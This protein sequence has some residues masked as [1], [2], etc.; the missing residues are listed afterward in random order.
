MNRSK[1]LGVGVALIAAIYLVPALVVF[2]FTSIAGSNDEDN[3]DGQPVAIGPKPRWWVPR[4]AHDYD[5][6][7]GFGYAPDGWPFVVWKP[8][9]LLFLKA[10][11]YV[12][13]KE[14]R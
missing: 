8:V 3:F 4:A 10:K 6:P 9:C 1:Q 11:G 14:W 7:G 2:D 5:I 12:P 13:P